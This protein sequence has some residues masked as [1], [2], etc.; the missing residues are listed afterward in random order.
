[1]ESLSSGTPFEAST[2]QCAPYYHDWSTVD[3]LHVT[4]EAIVPS[5]T[6]GVEIL[7]ASC[8]D[9]EEQCA[10]ISGAV[11]MET[12][13]WGDIVDETGASDSGALPDFID[14]SEL[15]NKFRDAPDAPEK[16]LAM[17][18]GDAEKGLIDPRPEVG[19][20]HVSGVVD[21]FR[22]LPYPHKPGKC[23][24]NSTMGC[25]SDGDCSA[26]AGQPQALC[27]LCGT[28]SGGACCHGDG[29][30]D[31]LPASACTGA[32]DTYKGDG[33]PCSRCCGP[34]PGCEPLTNPEW[35]DAQQLWPGL[36]RRDVCKEAAEDS[37]YNCISWTIDITDE[38]IWDEVDMDQNGLWEYSDIEAFFALYQKSAVIY[39]SN[40]HAVLHTA[41]PLPNNCASSKAGEW[42]R[43]R[44]D[45]N[46]I[47]GGYYG[48]I[49]GTHAY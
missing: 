5:S 27:V 39:G 10:D 14:I 16:P 19:F 33:E 47:E 25:I 43:L 32:D 6:Y 48:D 28:V 46:Q 13:R 29:T 34:S 22:G 42:I 3:L 31:I 41:R 12:S 38:W 18:V 23:S 1:V 9:N 11:L 36:D 45:R 40:S 37:A 15:V 8:L 49:L 44:H 30:C 21:S 17:L 20:S 4:G 2:L 35:L 26:A 24:N 7:A